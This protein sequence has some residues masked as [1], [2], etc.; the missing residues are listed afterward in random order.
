M[1][2]FIRRIK[3]LLHCSVF[4][5]F[6]ATSDNSHTADRIQTYNFKNV[7]IVEQRI[8]DLFHEFP[9]C[10]MLIEERL[11]IRTSSRDD[12]PFLKS[13]DHRAFE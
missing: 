13:L 9:N 8:N 11:E 3:T 6:H 5:F 4:K 1:R 2:K 7:V 10:L 12:L